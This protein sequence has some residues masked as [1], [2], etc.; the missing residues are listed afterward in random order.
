MTAP[1]ETHSLSKS[2]GRHVGLRDVTLEVAA[3]SIVGL[4]G[5]NGSGKTTLMRMLMGLISITS[6]QAKLFGRSV[7]AINVEARRNIGY[8][9]GTFKAYDNITV[10]RYLRFLSDLRRGDFTKNIAALCDR[11]SLDPS[12]TI[13]GLSKGT[14]QK[15]G[16]VQAFMHEPSLLILDEPTSGLDPLMQREFEAF[17]AEAVTHGATALLSSHVM[18]E[19]ERMARTIAVLD[20]GRLV[21][22]ATVDD[23]K[24]HVPH[25]IDVDFEAPPDI[26]PFR[27]ISGVTSAEL[28][29]NSLHLTVF[30]DETELIREASR[31]SATGIRTHEPT[32]DDLFES[33]LARTPSDYRHR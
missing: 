17:L 31:Q 4:L 23:V 21:S 27:N 32:L 8:L 2:Y 10:G 3:G 18:S 22:V 11:F 30:G 5:P 25:D 26:E 9:P 24:R 16:L 13:G 19:V 29:G 33:L 7:S 28:S 14:K 20:K 12:K 6:G 1:I 15:V